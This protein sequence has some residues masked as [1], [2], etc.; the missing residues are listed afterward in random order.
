MRFTGGH[1]SIV[2]NPRILLADDSVSI[3]KVVE[4]TFA[5]EGFDVV[6]VAD[7]EAAMKEFVAATPDCVIADVNMPEPGGYSLCEMIKSDETTREIPVVLVVGAFE[8]FDAGEAS[9][10]G[11]NY[12]FTKPFQS[13]RE[14]VEKV[15]D[16]IAAKDFSAVVPPGTEDI[17]T[18]YAESIVDD[19]ISDEIGEIEM[20]DVP[21]E[22]SEPPFGGSIDPASDAASPIPESQFERVFDDGEEDDQLI[23]AINYTNVSS[24][25][26]NAIDPFEAP[27]NTSFETSV[28]PRQGMVK[29]AIEDESDGSAGRDENVWPDI[30]TANVPTE[31]TFSPELIEAIAQRVLE[32]LSD[33]AVRDAAKEAVPR[34]AEKLI[35]EALEDQ[36]EPPPAADGEK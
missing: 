35:R 22:M 13:I 12:Y 1:N 26:M 29:F 33:K 2:N 16:L 23:E 10:V 6:T 7:G 20:P 32:K 3:R 15:S 27:A 21:I 30:S 34:I 5:D 14:V 18:L 8:P 36:S 19:Q 25:A 17:E 4:L 11:A 28:E 24:I 9:R 31:N